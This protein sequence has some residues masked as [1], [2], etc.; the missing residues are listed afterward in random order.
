VTLANDWSNRDAGPP[1]RVVSFNLA[2]NFDFAVSLG[3]CIVIDELDP[4]A[5]DVETRVNGDLRQ[6]YNSRDMVYSFAEILAYLST[7]FT[8]VPGDMILGGT[9]AGTAQDS[10]KLAADGSRPHDLFLN[11]GDSVEIS[12]PAIGKIVNRVV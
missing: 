12:S 4:Q 8:F 10:T 3:P 6:R 9:G 5:V 11:P 1:P 7:D 2:K